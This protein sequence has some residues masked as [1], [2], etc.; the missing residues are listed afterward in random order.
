MATPAK[1]VPPFLEKTRNS[2]EMYEE[3]SETMPGG[4]TANIKHFEPYPLFMES[5]GGAKL[6]DVDGNEY[7]D[8]N[9]CYGALMLGH[10][11]SRVIRAVKEQLDQ[12]GTPVFGTPHA[13]ESAV[14]KKLVQLYPG[15][16]TTRFTNSGL[17]ATM[18]AIRLAT[19]WTGRRK[20]AKFEG[21]YHG[22]YDQVLISVTPEEREQD[23]PPRSS[24]DS[25][26]VP[27]YYRDNTVVLPFNDWQQT[28]AILEKHRHELG[29]VILE[30]VQAGFIPP[31]IEFL[32]KLRECTLLYGIPL[33]F[34]EVK[35]GFRLGL[36]GA[37]GR[38][39]VIPDLTALGKV[40]GGGFPVGAVGGRQEIME[41]CS[42][43]RR[44]DILS[45]GGQDT[46]KNGGSDVLFHSGTYNGH[47]TVLSAGLATINALEETG[48]YDR[49]EQAAC[50]LR[51]EMEQILCD[52]GLCG[53]TVGVGTIFN[54]VLSDTPIREV[55]DLLRSD[56]HLRKKLDTALLE[57]GIYVKPGN[58]FSLSVAHTEDVLAETLERF[59]GGVR[60]LIRK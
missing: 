56:L 13:L 55:Q 45:F 48:V 24:V 32:K 58:R 57:R 19:G 10:G 35:T 28:E 21:H 12:M 40:L 44:S 2:A 11:N 29:A 43:N 30:P 42:P 16:E 38:Y 4:V 46:G 3:A 41:I 50:R 37:Q 1:P 15:I 31:D 20:I 49:V 8:Y 59:E 17:E 34:D 23:V 5:A 51:Q 47:P 52:F 39:G 18:L 36:S 26:G 6:Y 53:R 54:L 9:L 7:I 27:D 22:G 60:Q 33:I 14:A 25:L